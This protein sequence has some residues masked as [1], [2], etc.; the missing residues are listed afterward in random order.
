M[1][2]PLRNQI[3]VPMAAV[4]LMTVLAV[5]ITTAILAARRTTAELERLLTNIARTVKEARFPLT[6]PVLLQM[7]SLS[8]AEF[9]LVDERGQRLAQTITLPNEIT[10]PNDRQLRH[11]QT[12]REPIRL[13]LEPSLPLEPG[14]H[15][16]LA[17]PLPS[18][19][20]AAAGQTLHLLYPE[21][22][23]QRAWR[24]AVLPPLLIGGAALVG[25]TAVAGWIAARVS[26]PLAVLR[27]QVHEIADGKYQPL[28]LPPRD[29]EVRDVSRAVNRLAEKLAGYEAEVR[30]SERLRTLDQLGGGIAHQLR[31]SVTGCRLALDLHLDECPLGPGDE[32]LSVAKRQLALME[33]SIQR[34]LTLGQPPSERPTQPLDLV[35]LVNDIV[36]LVLPAMRHAQVDLRWTPPR[37]KCNLAAN[38]GELEQLTINLLLNALDAVAAHAQNRSDRW[39]E[40]LCESRDDRVRLQVRDSGPG[41]SAAVRDR[42]FTA[43]VTDKSGGV[44]LGLAVAQEIARRHGGEISWSRESD[45]TCFCV[46]LPRVFEN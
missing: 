46:D 19:G 22:N 31:N 28:P 36:P 2:W 26:R 21:A 17:V 40:I 8:G 11:P 20:S 24:D 3:V 15:F 29:D 41:P 25:M 12:S 30:R 14:P 5:S 13:R 44:G 33:A 37:D 27:R 16:H 10:L 34:F 1:R 38:P 18:R 7:R 4:L 42:L 9:V 45:V 23:Y 32:S 6:E 43:F 35:A 39:V